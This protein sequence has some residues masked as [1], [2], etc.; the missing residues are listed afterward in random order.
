MIGWVDATAGASGDMLLGALLDAGV[1]LEVV[2]RAVD[3][4]APEPVRLHVEEVRRAGLAALRCHVEAA[5]STARRTPADV[6]ALLDGADLPEPVRA[7]A[8]AVFDRLATAEAEVHGVGV[9][10]VHFHE[11]GALDAVADVV[12]VCAGF[13]HLGLTALTVS[14]VAVGSGRTDSEHGSLPVPVPAVARL[15]RGVPS[16][17]GPATAEACTPTGAALLVTLADG[18]G[19]QPPMTV[20]AVGSGAGG[21]DPGSHPNVTRLLVGEPVGATPAAVVV[22]TNVDDLDP[23]LWPDVLAALLAAGASD[24]WLTPILMKKG[25][26]AHT[27][28]VLVAPGRLAA[29]RREVFRHTSTIGV[30]EVGYAKTALDREVHRVDVDGHQVRVKVAR[31]DGEVVNVQPEYDDVAAVARTTGRSGK[32]VL[33]DAC[34]RARALRL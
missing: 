33:A 7:S 3:A 5:P 18:F 21:R 15:L 32:D 1:P 2:Q 13:H 24:A 17:A 31:L 14:T 30:R 25:R 20:A 4:A 9:E 22:E 29:V 10:K 27:L 19:P 11:V 28:S 16:Y 34:S 6:R 8:Q 26:P 23:R 12:G